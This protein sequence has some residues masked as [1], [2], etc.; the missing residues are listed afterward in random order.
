MPA[1]PYESPLASNL[2]TKPAAKSFVLAALVSLH[3]SAVLYLLVGFFL[4]ALLSTLAAGEHD[5]E[6]GPAIFG[7]FLTTFC[8]ALAA[9]VEVVAYGVHKRRFWGWIAGLVVFGIYVPSLFFPLGAVGLWG[10]LAPGS[11]AE[12][13]VGRSKNA[14]T[15]P[16]DSQG[17]R[18]WGG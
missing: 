11:L 7:T 5:V 10:L 17:A 1:N 12:F 13:G 4:P 18:P 3:V 6:A 9:G 16:A 15:P 2:G 8:V 14:P